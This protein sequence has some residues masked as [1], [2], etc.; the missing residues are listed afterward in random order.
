MR[1]PTWMRSL[2]L[3]LQVRSERSRLADLMGL[4]SIAQRAYAMTGDLHA[5]AQRAETVADLAHQIAV[6]RSRI[7]RLRK[8]L[9]RLAAGQPEPAHGHV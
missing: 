1:A 2:V 6:S 8:S 5:R 7:A 9:C 3:R 4:E